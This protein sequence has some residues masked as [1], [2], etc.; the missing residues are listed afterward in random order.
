LDGA[1]TCTQWLATM[2][3]V[4]KKAARRRLRVGA[5]L[6]KRP[7]VEAAWRDGEITEAQV[8]AIVS[9]DTPSTAVA[10]ARDEELLVEQART[11]RFE[12]FA[13]A[14]AYWRLLA[15]RDGAEKDAEAR[16]ASREMHLSQSFDGMWFGNL[17][18]DPV[19]GEIVST[20]LRRIEDELF[21]CDAREAEERLGPDPRPHE[22]LRT[23]EQRRVDALVEMAVRSA[24]VPEGAQRPLPLI[25]VLVDAPT[26]FERVCELASGAVVTAAD[27][28]PLVLRA[29][30]ERAVFSTPNRVDISTRSRLFTGATRRKIVVRDRGCQHEFCDRRAVV[31]Q[32][33][34]VI[35][36]SQGGLTTE[37]NGRL[38]CGFHNRLR[39]QRPPPAA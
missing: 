19:S 5:R 25:N 7:A 9:L 14:L 18:L 2:T 30:F 37:E 28:A 29:E 11:L 24:S 16:R 33:D 39:N 34:H 32:V 12:A 17:T 13:R 15:D 26:T 8:A 31:C 23:P 22:F 36:W 4:P 3:H 1:Q 6:R 10:L 20:A 35:P 27:V 38:L 21:L